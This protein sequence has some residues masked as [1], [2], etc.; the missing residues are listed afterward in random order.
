VRE[1]L[2]GGDA[3]VEYEDE[4]EGEDEDVGGG[5]DLDQIAF[6]GSLGGSGGFVRS[7]GS[8]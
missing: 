8:A 3:P 5:D 2:A 4:D 6:G 7:K 1:L